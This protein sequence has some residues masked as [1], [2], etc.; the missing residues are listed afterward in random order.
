M[1]TTHIYYTVT[2]DVCGNQP[3]GLVGEYAHFGTPTDALADAQSIDWWATDRMVICWCDWDDP[4][5]VERA[6]EYAATLNETELEEFLEWCPDYWPEIVPEKPRFEP[7]M[8]G[9]TLIPLAV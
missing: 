9:Q 7:A 5:H 1:I 2:C 4:D 3:E 6:R 8:P